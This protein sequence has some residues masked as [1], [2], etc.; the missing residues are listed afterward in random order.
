MPAE[1]LRPVPDPTVLTTAALMN[2]T[3]TLRREMQG[4]REYFSKEIDLLRE[5]YT[6]KIDA[7]VQIS[8]ERFD[9]VR[10]QFLIVEAQREEQKADT[11]KAVEAALAAQKEAVREQ[12][13]ASQL[14]IDKSG[15]YLSKQVDQQGLSFTTALNA[16]RETDNDIKD[17][18]TRI[19]QQK[20]GGE[21]KIG[22]IYAAI[23]IAVSI[24]VALLIATTVVLAFIN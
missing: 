24:I 13:M 20:V 6:V 4:I 21:A 23:G 3:R 5:I 12:T 22:S 16:L 17:R 15:G 8:N 7:V 2:E 14:A 18:L 1:E 11:Q 9:R 10:D 19:E